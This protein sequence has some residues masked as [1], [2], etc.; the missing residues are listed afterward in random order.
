[1]SKISFQTDTMSSLLAWMDENNA[2]AEEAAV[3]Y[4]TTYKDRWS[5]WL[6]DDAREK[7]GSVLSAG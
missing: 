2:S 3:H 4:L 7:L 1:M 6:S 5:S